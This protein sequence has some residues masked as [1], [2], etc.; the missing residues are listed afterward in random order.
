MKIHIKNG[1]IVDP[2]N[3]IDSL[4]DLFISDGKIAAVG[5]SPDNFLIDHTIDAKNLIVIPGLVDLSAR[6]RE[7]GYEYRATLESELNAAL[8]GGVTSLLCPPDTDPV[9]DEPG[10]VEMLVHR[11]WMLNQSHVYPLGALTNGLKGIELTEMAEL[12]DAGCIGFAQPDYIIENISVMMKAMQYANTFGYSVWLSPQEP[13][14]SKF[15]KAH[16]GPIAS[17]LGLSEIPEISETIALHIIFELMRITG[18]RVHICRL[19]SA[20]G[21]QLIRN[22]KSSGLLISC[23]VSAHHVHLTENDIAF[24]DSNA[25]LLPPLRSQRD[26]EA[27]RVGLADGTVNAICSD[28]TPVDDDEKLLPFAEASAGATCLELLLPLSLRWAEE[29][30]FGNKKNIKAIESI[31]SNP[32]KVANL[33]AGSL[34]IGSNADICIYNPDKYWTVSSSELLSQGKN[35]PFYG[36]ELRGQVMYTIVSGRVVFKR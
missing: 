7:P 13:S 36:Y 31:T 16:S 11:A 22:A 26:K 33:D 28:H 29:M 3:E 27:I 30:N 20:A 12:V 23:D 14:L 4:N 19:S 21:V 18:A 8:A 34:S 32:A 5:V 9:L 10:L 15:G 24:F 35:T 25:R 1:H 17:R 2:V 6:L